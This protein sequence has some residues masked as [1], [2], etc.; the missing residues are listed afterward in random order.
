MEWT[1]L[2][3]QARALYEAGHLN[4]A[5]HALRR[6]IAF[7][8][9]SSQAHFWLGFVLEDQGRLDE[10]RAFLEAGLSLEENALLLVIAGDVQRRLGDLDAAER[11]LARAIELDPAND[12]AHHC[13][14][15]VAI[16][17]Q[18]FP[19]ALEHLT[20]AVRLDPEPSGRR[21]ALA[22]ALYALNRL[23]EAEVLSR[24]AIA[25]DPG[26]AWAPYLMGCI[27]YSRNDWSSAREWFA[28]SV[29]LAPDVGLFWTG[30]GEMAAR[31]GFEDEADRLFRE[32]LARGPGDSILNRKYGVF[33]QWR[34]SMARGRTYL[35]RALSLNPND[36]VARRMLDDLKYTADKDHE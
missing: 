24:E 10:A 36:R 8:S 35:Q 27:F 11:S 5:E 13:L 6:S 25:S 22:E 7:K 21:L 1:K 23:D 28:R 33:L 20:E 16:A 17:K 12:E 29:E 2:L 14:G 30:L 3:D 9:D 15:R 19:T 18:D 4:E 32:A 26:D 34:G 31:L